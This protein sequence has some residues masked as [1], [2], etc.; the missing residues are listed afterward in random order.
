M[1]YHKIG[2]PL[3]QGHSFV[4]LSIPGYCN[5]IGISGLRLGYEARPIIPENNNYTTQRIGRRRE[6]KLQ[7]G[8]NV[9]MRILAQK[10]AT[11]GK[12]GTPKIITIPNGLFIF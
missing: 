11:V 7:Q 3:G 6:D 5:P 8:Y 10:L 9:T 2:M 12:M 4:N 1:K